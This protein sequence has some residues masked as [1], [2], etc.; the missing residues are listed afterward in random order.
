[1]RICQISNS[2]ITQ[3]E[4]DF[5]W[6]TNGTYPVRASYCEGLICV[7]VAFLWCGCLLED[8]RRVSGFV[9]TR[10]CLFLMMCV[11][12]TVS[13]VATIVLFLA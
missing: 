3:E 4:F 12:R 5:Y 8:Q 7:G 1:M 9:D 6:K 10:C 2:R 13:F 11:Y